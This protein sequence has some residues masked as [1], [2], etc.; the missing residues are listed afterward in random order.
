MDA[1]ST[2]AFPSLRIAVLKK[3][4][5][6]TSFATAASTPGPAAAAAAV[7]YVPP[8][9]R[10]KDAPP[11]F[12]SPVAF[13]SLASSVASTPK[14]AWGKKTPA[15]TAATPLSEESRAG[16][17]TPSSTT[18]LNFKEMMKERI[19]KDMMEATLREIPETD[20]PVEMSDEKLIGDGWAILKISKAAT[21]WQTPFD[22]SDDP[23]DAF[24]NE[25]F[26]QMGIPEE[27]KTCEDSQRVLEYLCRA[28][29]AGPNPWKP[30]AT[31]GGM[32]FPMTPKTPRAP[33]LMDGILERKRVQMRTPRP[34]AV[35]EASA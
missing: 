10:D 5:S 29:A 7:A 35:V 6:Y 9:K 2:S 13:P 31:G 22:V 19:E 24:V 25:V 33:T 27:L 8:S 28:G 26:R 12:M 11:D 16:S 34:V 30:V 15:V 17:A 32:D 18:T 1:S 4:D 3:N 14:G 21:R 23:D 20:D